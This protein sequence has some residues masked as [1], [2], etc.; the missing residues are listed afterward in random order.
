MSAEIITFRRPSIRKRRT[1]QE[2]PP[3]SLENAVRLAMMLAEAAESHLG[4]YLKKRS[5]KYRLKA[6]HWCHSYAITE[7]RRAIEA[8]KAASGSG[9]G[10]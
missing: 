7:L 5:P 4:R 1:K 3:R 2:P 8:Y 10:A 6:V 9:T